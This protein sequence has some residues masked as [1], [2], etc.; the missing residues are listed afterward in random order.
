MTTIII[1]Q[2]TVLELNESIILTRNGNYH[3]E[4]MHAYMHSTNRTK[5]QSDS[6]GALEISDTTAQ[7]I[8][9]I[10]CF[11]RHNSNAQK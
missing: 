9:P 10:K 1:A 3:Y 2:F 5:L 8:V 7:F 11:Y 6:L 4:I